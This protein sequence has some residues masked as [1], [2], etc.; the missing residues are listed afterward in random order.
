[1][2]GVDE[3]RRGRAREPE[4][5]TLRAFIASLLSVCEGEALLSRGDHVVDV[6]LP[7]EKAKDAFNGSET[8]RP[9]RGAVYIFL[10]VKQVPRK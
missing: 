6:P 10:D 1:M 8:G 4:S 7:E 9:E 5:V 3:E 2:H